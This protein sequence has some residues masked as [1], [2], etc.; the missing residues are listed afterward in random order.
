M[1][2]LP[3]KQASTKHQLAENRKS[4]KS[5]NIPKVSLRAAAN[6]AVTAEISPLT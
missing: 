3:I 4:A 6:G 2:R 1:R 5:V